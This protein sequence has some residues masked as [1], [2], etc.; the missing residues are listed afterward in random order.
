MSTESKVQHGTLELRLEG[1]T[2]E[3]YQRVAEAADVS[4]EAVLAVMAAIHLV[5]TTQDQGGTLESAKVK[6]S[7]SKE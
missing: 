4:L 2:L 5:K 6:V 7:E 1:T 3:F